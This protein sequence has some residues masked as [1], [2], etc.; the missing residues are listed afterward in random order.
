MSD[1]Q[2]NNGAIKHYIVSLTISSDEFLKLYQGLAR[3]VA[4]Q[5]REGVRIQFPASA[6]KPYLSRDGIAGTFKL[7]VDKNNKLIEL[8][9][10]G[11]GR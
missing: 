9:E 8:V 6:L 3:N 7:T 11:V 5:T 10:M 4:T 2:G 1:S